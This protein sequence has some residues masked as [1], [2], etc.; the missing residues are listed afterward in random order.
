M[1]IWFGLGRKFNVFFIL[2]II[3]PVIVIG[4]FMINM[5][6][7]V[8]ED[9]LKTYSIETL[10]QMG[11]NL[12][13]HIKMVA[14]AA[15]SV[16]SNDDVM[17]NIK[18]YDSM[19]PIEKIDTEVRMQNWMAGMFDMNTGISGLY[20][21]D[22]AGNYFYVK[23]RSP[24][25]NYDARKQEWYQK[26]M[27]SDGAFVVFGTH[28][29]FHASNSPELVITITYALKDFISKEIIG[30]IMVDIPYKFLEDTLRD[31]DSRFYHNSDV[32]VLDENI[33]IIYNQD[34]AQL[35]QSFPLRL[36]GESEKSSGMYQDRVKGEKVFVV[37]YI[38][39][40]TGWSIVSIQPQIAVLDGL[41]QV[42]ILFACM[43]FAFLII[44]FLCSI[45][46]SS[47]LI[48]PIRAMSYAVE[49]VKNGQYDIFLPYQQHDEI[50]VL[51]K[52]LTSMANHIEELIRKVYVSQLLERE[53]ELAALQN[54]INPHFLYNSLQCVWGMVQENNNPDLANMVKALSNYTR[55]NVS[56]SLDFVTIEDEIKQICNY[57]FIQ[58]IRHS[59]K[60]RV[61]FDIP[62]EY[63]CVRTMKLML[64]PL[65]ENAILHGLERKMGEGVICISL[66]HDGEGLIFR[67]SDNGLGMTDT[68]LDALNEK[69]RRSAFARPDTVSR[70]DR[71]GVLNVH[72]RIRLYFG[73]RYGLHYSRSAEGGVCVSLTIPKDKEGG[74]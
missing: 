61:I 27:D 38:S 69:L 71:I 30:V 35:F 4:V 67:I 54:Q 16:L 50:T 24:A 46:V 64:Q 10:R 36:S 59:G 2:C 62:E 48:R 41:I 43:I 70:K 25:R 63:A 37:Y 39:P 42:D 20:I 14:D 40:Y 58:N 5:T 68:Q 22:Q 53:A 44:F 45:Y 32:Y 15:S 28:E 26:T 18:H 1:R 19:G 65:V 8:I 56:N 29:Q 12:D 47:R 49:Q 11:K 21:F 72:N 7:K 74:S 23:G 6:G 52:G 3:I 51:A 66:S 13:A 31:D 55:Y 73:D 34:Q 9:K 17:Y 33:T 60:F 57:I